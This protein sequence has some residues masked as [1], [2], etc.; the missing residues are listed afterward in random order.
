MA[1]PITYRDRN[2]VDWVFREA[3]AQWYSEPVQGERRYD[4][5]PSGIIAKTVK[6]LQVATEA[7][8]KANASKV[9][10]VVRA[11]AD[12]AGWILILLAVVALSD[13]KW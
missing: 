1:E 3:G 12:G 5:E 7:Y 8:A 10:L 11:K 9:T 6:E 4:P 2:G 13:N